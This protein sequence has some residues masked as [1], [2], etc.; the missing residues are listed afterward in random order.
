MTPSQIAQEYGVPERTVS[1]WIIGGK[2]PAERG[3]RGSPATAT[4]VNR[5]DVLP[6]ISKWEE[7]NQKRERARQERLQKRLS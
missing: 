6:L 7:I 2:L 1:S 4:R 5:A 3:K